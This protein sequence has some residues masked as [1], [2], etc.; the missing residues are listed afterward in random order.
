VTD[1]PSPITSVPGQLGLSARFVD[2]ELV[3]DLE[4]QEGALHHGIVRASVVSFLVDAVAG[5]S[6]DGDPD[7]WTFTTDMSVRMRPVPV[8]APVSGV[9]TVVRQGRRSVTC[10]VAVVT[11]DGAP[12][13]SGAIGFA[14]VPRR[15]DDLPKPVVGP[16]HAPAI[17]QGLGRLSRPL[18][19]EAGVVS[20]DAAAGVAEVA[21]TPG[22]CN[23]AGTLQGAM[24]AL[25]AEA[26]V[27]DLLEARFGVSAVVVDIDLRYLAQARVGPVRATARLLGD[28]PGD[29]VQVE[30]TDT[31]T[32]RVTTLVYARAVVVG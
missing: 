29:P 18:R 25:L 4:P 28:G 26:A 12:F 16:E 24:V 6:V 23:P 22:I 11:A 32:G 13:A 9:N 1:I 8:H 2:G 5:I 17:F 31:S 30:L 14:H 20:V 19:E 21:V 3:L 27:E 10:T 15:A 7:V